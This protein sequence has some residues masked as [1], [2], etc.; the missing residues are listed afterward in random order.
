MA[1]L[2]PMLLSL[3]MT[4]VQSYCTVITRRV[5]SDHFTIHYAVRIRRIWYKLHGKKITFDH[6]QR[7]DLYRNIPS[8]KKVSQ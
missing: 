2:N 1:A 4:G 6:Y 5:H 7:V 3:Q 8:F